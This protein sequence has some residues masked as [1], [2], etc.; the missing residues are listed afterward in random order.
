M[1]STSL[2]SR[3]VRKFYSLKVDFDPAIT[4]SRNVFAIFLLKVATSNV[5]FC[6]TCS[7]LSNELAG[8]RHGLILR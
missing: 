5:K 6:K 8:R 1:I 4:I 7:R 3:N 2:I